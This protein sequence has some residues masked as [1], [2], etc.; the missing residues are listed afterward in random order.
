LVLRDTDILESLARR[1]LI[2]V[3]F[4]I[5]PLR[6]TLLAKL[7]PYASPNQKRLE[8]MNTLTK[9]GI[10]C[11]LYLS[12][13]FP[14]LSDSFLI[15]CLKRASESGAKCSAVIHGVSYQ[16]ETLKYFKNLG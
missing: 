2:A 15:P 11:S 6:K 7:E 5:T 14:F 10:P 3:N 8:A 12:P 13:I 4:T 9:A 1:N 16:K